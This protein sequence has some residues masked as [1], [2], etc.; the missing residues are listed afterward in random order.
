MAGKVV[1]SRKATTDLQSLGYTL[2]EAKECIA[3]LSQDKFRKFRKRLFYEDSGLWW[4][5]HVTTHRG[6]DG[7]VRE[8][9]VKLRI[10]SPST[11]DYVYVTS[12]H[13]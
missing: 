9:Y 3:S 12:F 13:I 1:F 7:T 11:V 2:E 5:A 6:P 10:P 4:D 8:I